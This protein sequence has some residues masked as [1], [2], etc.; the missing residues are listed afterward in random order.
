M[1]RHYHTYGFY[2]IFFLASLLSFGSIHSQTQSLDRDLSSIHLSH[3]Y[4]NV[5]RHNRI[6]DV[7][8]EYVNRENFIK[9]LYLT[10]QTAGSKRL[11]DFIELANKTEI[12]AFVIDGKNPNGSLP[13]IPEDESLKDYSEKNKM[14]LK[15]LNEILKDL[16]KNNIY[17]IARIIIFLDPFYASK[18]PDLIFYNKNKQPWKDFNGNKWLNPVNQQM[19]DYNVR[20]AKELHE[21]GFDEI[22]FDYIRFPSDGVI[23]DLTWTHKGTKEETMRDFFKYLHAELREKENIKISADLFGLTFNMTEFDLNIGQRLE[24]AAPYFDAISPMVY[25]SHYPTGYMGF[26]NPANYPYEVIYQAMEKGKPIYKKLGLPFTA[27][28]W[29][30]AFDMGAL[31]NRERTR[32]QMQAIED[33]EGAGWILWNARNEYKSEILDEEIQK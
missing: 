26:K 29:I 6:V 21:R 16:K 19:W 3:L 12:N 13:F 23:R 5:L 22:Q 7:K 25:P 8:T 4:N 10:A 11:A 24:Y 1:R 9:G 31:Y 33:A 28:P 20:V 30:Q 14:P 27:R 18:H 17:S 32:L 15:N 2:G